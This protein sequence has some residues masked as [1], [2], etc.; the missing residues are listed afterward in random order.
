[1][2]PGTPPT[3]SIRSTIRSVGRTSR[4]NPFGSPIA[5][6]FQMEF[7]A[8]DRVAGIGARMPRIHDRRTCT[9]FQHL[10][11]HFADALRVGEA[12]SVT[13]K[14]HHRQVGQGG[15]LSNRI[16]LRKAAGDLV[17]MGTQSELPSRVSCP[18][19]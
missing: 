19:R 4:G 15:G 14:E 9:A 1:M 7:L 16:V 5:L 6:G 8:A 13:V 11:F 17:L 2:W 18:T 12:F 3:T 10:L